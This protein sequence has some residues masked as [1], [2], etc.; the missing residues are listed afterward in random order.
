MNY[1]AL[2][3][4]LKLK[5]KLN[6]ENFQNNC[7]KLDVNIGKQLIRVLSVSMIKPALLGDLSGPNT[8]DHIKLTGNLDN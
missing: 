2:K 6:L 8:R 5:I 4:S 7:Y 1:K 3:N